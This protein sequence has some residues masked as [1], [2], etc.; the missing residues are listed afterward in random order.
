[1]ELNRDLLSRLSFEASIRRSRCVSWGG[2]SNRDCFQMYEYTVL[3]K[4]NYY[5]LCGLI[6]VFYYVRQ[7]TEPAY[8]QWWLQQCT[9]FL[10]QSIARQYMLIKYVSPGIWRN[11]KIEQATL[12]KICCTLNYKP[13]LIKY[14]LNSIAIMLP[15]KSLYI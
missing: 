2:R 9:V 12:H 14:T 3:C 11:I 7:N 1:M 6:Y 15:L 4:I 13:V 5:I 10:P 8:V